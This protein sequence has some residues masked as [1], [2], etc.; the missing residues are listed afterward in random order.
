MRK[1]ELR[2]QEW[3]DFQPVPDPESTAER[4][5]ASTKRAE[6]RVGERAKQEA[7]KPVL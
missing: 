7:G 3:R 2:T 1:P 4:F 6:K 5:W